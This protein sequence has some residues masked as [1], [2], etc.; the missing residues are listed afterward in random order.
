M[1]FH[2]NLLQT[3]NNTGIEIPP[4][5]IEALGGGKKPAVRLTVN[6]YAYRNTVAVMGGKY[7]VSFSSEHRAASGIRGGDAIEVDIEL[8]TAPREVAVPADFA[9]ALEAAGLRPA[10]DK[11]APSHRKEHVRAIEDAK[12]AETRARRI[13]K[14]VAK[15]AGTPERGVGIPRRRGKT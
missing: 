12:T 10:F 8:D 4:E 2:T 15:I 9:E 5:V 13:A 7:M 6:G 1:K 11:L 14:A 3:G